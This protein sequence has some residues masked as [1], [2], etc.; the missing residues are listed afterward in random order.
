MKKAIAILFITAFFTS[1]KTDSKSSIS[2][3]GTEETAIKE[4][5]GLF[6]Y[7]ADAAVLR[8]PNELFGVV[9]NKKAQELIKMAEPLKDNYTDEV[10]V[11]L[12]VKTV[13]KPEN[14]EGWE[15]RVEIIDIINV[16]KVEQ[17]DSDLKKLITE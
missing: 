7:Y 13:K 5:T 11:T 9:E 16:S 12:N 3:K 2:D 15:Y 1:C 6:T 10:A 14:E 8:T 17:K 4:I